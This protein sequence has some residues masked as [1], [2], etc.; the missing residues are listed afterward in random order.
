MS[1]I[2][3]SMKALPAYQRR[4]ESINRSYNASR[5]SA[6][7]QSVI[8]RNLQKQQWQIIGI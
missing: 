6:S 1:A 3:E 8:S 7:M 5:K 4:G 2:N